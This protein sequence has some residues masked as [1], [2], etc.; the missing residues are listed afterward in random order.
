M[1]EMFRGSKEQGTREQK[2]KKARETFYRKLNLYLAPKIKE[3]IRKIENNEDL[4]QKFQFQDKEDT[5]DLVSKI[6]DLIIDLI[7]NGYA[8]RDKI[9]G[10][11]ELV[12]LIKENLADIQDLFIV[13]RRK[14]EEEVEEIDPQFLKIVLRYCQESPEIEGNFPNELETP[15][16]VRAYLY[17]LLPA[18]ERAVFEGDFQ[19]LISARE[20]WDP[21]KFFEEISSFVEDFMEGKKRISVLF[22]KEWLPNELR[23]KYKDNLEERLKELR[24]ESRGGKYVIPITPERI[25]DM[26][27]EVIESRLEIT[28]KFREIGE[29]IRSAQNLSKEAKKYLSSIPGGKSIAV[30]YDGLL[31]SIKNSYTEGIRRGMTEEEAKKLLDSVTKLESQLK[32]LIER[33]KSAKSEAEKKRLLSKAKDW[34]RANGGTILS[35]IGLWGLAIGWFLPLWLITKMYDAIAESKLAKK[36]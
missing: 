33:G 35:A 34:L 19:R 4:R 26:I 15:E 24:I 10:A 27:N 17:L 30:V 36:G 25:Q 8:G 9:L 7:K 23:E 5:K 22:P 12:S 13:R 28:D 32:Y 18:E 29:K 20:D 11:E 6:I 2:E 16:A 14:G 31:T 1:I 21:N 3:L